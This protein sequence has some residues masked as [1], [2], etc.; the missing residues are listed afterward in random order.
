MKNKNIPPNHKQY[1]VSIGM[2]LGLVIGAVIGDR[3][4]HM[5]VGAV[6]GMFIGLCCGRFVDSGK[7]KKSKDSLDEED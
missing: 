3:S 4:I 5:A 1:Y 6:A 2:C 7:R